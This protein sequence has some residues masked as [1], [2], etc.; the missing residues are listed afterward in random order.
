LT[1]ISESPQ[2]DIKLASNN[3][4]IMFSNKNFNL[5]SENNKFKLNFFVK[6][7]PSKIC[8]PVSN[9]SQKIIQIDTFLN[10]WMSYQNLFKNLMQFERLKFFVLNS[11]QL[12]IFNVMKKYN[13]EK[14]KSHEE[15]RN[16]SQEEYEKINHIQDDQFFKKMSD[17]DEIN[18]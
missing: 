15:N 10:K 11:E 13:F 6:I 9:Q 18:Y 5:A 12:K 8:E 3:K 7:C 14:M 16:L 1:P 17:F 2:K 4:V